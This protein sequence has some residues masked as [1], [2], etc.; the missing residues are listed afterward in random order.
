ME[1]SESLEDLEDCWKEYLGRVE[2]VWYKS[3]AHFK[4]SPKWNN[5]KVSFEKQRSTD[6][7]L[8]YLRNARGADE[9][10]VADIAEYHDGI[11]SIVAGEGGGGTIRNLR[12]SNGHV[13]A[14][15]TGSV[16]VVFNPF[17]IRLLSVTNR[18]VVYPVPN[19]HNG[20]PIDPEN[21]IAV[22]KVGLVFYENFLTEA[23]NFFVDKK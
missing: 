7:L 3:S 22:A 20:A 16:N 15:T 5:W 1:S 4:K 12:I 2:R 14:E 9:H 6:P 17:R 18:G 23:E 10:T 11:I 13:T 8:S 21:V 19:S